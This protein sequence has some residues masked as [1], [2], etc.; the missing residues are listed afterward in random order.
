MTIMILRKKDM[1]QFS[2]FSIHLDRAFSAVDFLSMMRQHLFIG[3][4]GIKEKLGYE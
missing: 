4:L 1:K 2:G 3:S